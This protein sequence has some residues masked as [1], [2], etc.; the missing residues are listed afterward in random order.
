M[1]K[2]KYIFFYSIRA[3]LAAILVTGLLGCNKGEG[4]LTVE[5]Y[6]KVSSTDKE[7][8]LPH[9]KRPSECSF[10]VVM[11]CNSCVYDTQGALSGSESE[12]CGVCVGGSF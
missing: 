6:P 5:C 12:I 11:M 8:K 9:P 3:V 7:Q 10:G 4:S 2:H 1:T